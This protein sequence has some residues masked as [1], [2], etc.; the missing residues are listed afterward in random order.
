MGRAVTSMAGPQHG[1]RAGAEFGAFCGE[2]SLAE[3]RKRKSQVGAG[4]QLLGSLLTS[5]ETGD[6]LLGMQ[7]S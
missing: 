6:A 1:T 5:E 3:V 2:G 7:S 4:R